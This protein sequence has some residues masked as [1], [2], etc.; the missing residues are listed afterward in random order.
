MSFLV[1]DDAHTT[2]QVALAFIDACDNGSSSSIYNSNSSPGPSSS[3]SGSSSPAVSNQL[4]RTAGSIDD[5][6]YTTMDTTTSLDGSLNLATAVRQPTRTKQSDAVM[7]SRAKKK[8]ETQLLREQV[9]ELEATVRE[10]QH[11]RR[12][13]GGGGS[14]IG[15]RDGDYDEMMLTKITP[16]EE[17]SLWIEVATTQARERQQAQ[18]LNTKLKDAVE[19]QGKAI[20][21]LEA[22][23]RRLTG[24]FVSLLLCDLLP[25]GCGYLRCIL[26]PDTVCLRPSIPFRN[27]TYCATSRSSTCITVRQ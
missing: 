6:V 25:Y 20:K 21:T 27:L 1:E 3:S 13:A 5:D 2:L 16:K 9:A 4:Y 8:V 17:A 18:L 24:Q 10:L 23:L 7:R 26:I 14:S 12:R 22:T 15:V 11:T 19:K